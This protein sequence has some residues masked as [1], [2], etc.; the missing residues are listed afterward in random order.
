MKRNRKQY[1]SL[2]ENSRFYILIAGISVSAIVYFAVRIE[3]IDATLRGI[4]I[5]QIYALIAVLC[6]YYVMLLTAFAKVSPKKRWLESLL[7]DRRAIGVLVAYFALLHTLIAFFEQ[8]GGWKGISLLAGIAQ[9]SVLLGTAAIIVLLFMAVLSTD[10]VTKLTKFKAW[11]T[12]AR[13][14]YGAGIASL[15]HTW[16]IGTHTTAGWLQ[17]TVF[18]ALLLLF[19]LNAWNMS[20][21]LQKK[22]LSQSL[23]R[24]IALGLLLLLVG[25]LVAM[26]EY[27]SSY[28][29][30]HQNHIAP[31]GVVLHAH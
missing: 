20:N 19:V 18:V 2:L 27:V 9:T 17:L 1:K 22:R 7:Y 24:L 8:L 12:L 28:G 29:S 13:V 21:V 15:V 25:G 3:I 16:M 4:R 30:A 6:W 10:A 31:D 5:Q 14:A 26:K 23:S 11:K